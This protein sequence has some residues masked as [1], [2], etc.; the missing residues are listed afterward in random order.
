MEAVTDPLYR[1]KLL[2]RAD[3]LREDGHSLISA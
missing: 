2:S 1:P 3:L